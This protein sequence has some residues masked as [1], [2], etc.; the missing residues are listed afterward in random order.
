MEILFE[1]D[2]SRVKNPKHLTKNIFIIYSPGT[3]TVE[4]ASCTN[5]DTNI[6]L[7][8]PKKKQK[9]FLLLRPEDSKFSKL[10][11]RKHA[12]G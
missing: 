1:S 4:T 2:N 9:L 5:I 11:T 6:I 7:K 3:V 10:I 12:F 8:L